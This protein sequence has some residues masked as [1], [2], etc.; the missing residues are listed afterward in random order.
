MYRKPKHS[1]TVLYITE[2]IVELLLGF[3]KARFTQSG[4]LAI[5]YFCQKLGGLVALNTRFR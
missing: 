2:P 3:L 1:K 5:G 4:Y